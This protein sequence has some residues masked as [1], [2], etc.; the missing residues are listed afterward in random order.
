MRTQ[1]EPITVNLSDLNRSIEKKQFIFF[2][3]SYIL[4]LIILAPYFLVI[5]LLLVLLSLYLVFYY[6]NKSEKDRLWTGLAK[7][8][9]HQLGTPLSSLIGWNEY[10]KSKNKIDKKI[11]SKEIDKDLNRLKII[12]DRFSNIGSKPKLIE[13]N[14]SQVIT[15]SINY[16]KE[17]TSQKIK[18]KLDL[19]V[20]NL[21]FNEQ[22]FSWVIENLYKNSI[23]AVSADG[24][25]TIKLVNKKKIVEIDFIDNGKGIRKNEFKTI[26]N[27]GFTTKERGW[28]LGLTLAQRI[29]E[30]YHKGK[31]YVHNQQKTSKQ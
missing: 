6:S 12:T 25:V 2:K 1:Y 23:D 18:T 17:R 26:F 27:P 3:N 5:F 29:I 24:K 4:D 11:V 7:E 10:I 30:N 9:A 19:D 20:V 16:L 14:I 22:L 31:I 21:K 15:N 28:G 13:N 8:T